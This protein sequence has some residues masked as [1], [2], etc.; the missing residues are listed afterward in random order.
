MSAM[1]HAPSDDRRCEPN[2]WACGP[3]T[4]LYCGERW[5]CEV[6]QLRQELAREIQAVVIKD[7]AAGPDSPWSRGMLDAANV[8]LGGLKEDS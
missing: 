7:K 8:V 5:P 6:A 4:C 3:R 1:H 2:C